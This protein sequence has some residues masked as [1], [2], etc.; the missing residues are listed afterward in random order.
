MSVKTERITILG[1]PD[2]KAFLM[3]EA[4]KEGVSVS[5]LVRSRCEKES[6]DADDEL[7]LELVAEVRAS[8]TTARKSLEKGLKEAESTLKELRAS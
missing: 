3:S 6:A 5:Q 2:F 8:T 7:L 1:S 4:E